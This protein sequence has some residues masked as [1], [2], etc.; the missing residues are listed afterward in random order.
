MATTTYLSN[1]DVII[2]TVNLRDQCTSATLT[3]TVE[4]LESTAFGDI[5]RFMSPGLQNNELTLTLYMSYAASETYASLAA[6]VGTQVT[7]IVSPAAPTT[8]GTYSATNPGFTLT[9]TYLESLPVINATMGE[10]STI[11]ITFTGGA[12]TVDV[13]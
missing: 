6:L 2:A 1:P 7:V 8:P 12:Y 13:S 9:G 10:L 3:Q 4:A 5:A 11:D